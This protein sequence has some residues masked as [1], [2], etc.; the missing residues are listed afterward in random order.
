MGWGDE[1]FCGHD[2]AI[3]IFISYVAKNIAVCDFLQDVMS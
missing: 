2:N 3:L 1:L